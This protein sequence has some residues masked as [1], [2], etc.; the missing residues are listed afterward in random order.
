[1]NTIEQLKK[2][3]SIPKKYD[4]PMLRDFLEEYK[5]I[6]NINTEEL[7]NILG[8]KKQ[9]YSKLNYV[10]KNTGEHYII[11]LSTVLHVAEKLHIPPRVILEN[12][13]GEEVT[14]NEVKD[15][16]KG[17]P[18]DVKAWLCTDEG[19]SYILKGFE[20]H[21][22]EK[23]QEDIEK[24][25]DIQRKLEEQKAIEINNTKLKRVKRYILNS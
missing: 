10:N 9:Y 12:I 7:C 20:E 17:L 14:E 23:S 1:M 8:W 13:Y 5:L 11:T 21:L 24:R 22:T 2:D 3:K 18:S 25:I 19:K 4:G 16:I 6:K 15:F